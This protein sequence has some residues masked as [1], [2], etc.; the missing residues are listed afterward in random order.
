MKCRITDC[1]NQYWQGEFK[2]D[3]CFPCY[4]ELAS[5]VEDLKGHSQAIRDIKI[6]AINSLRAADIYEINHNKDYNK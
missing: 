1:K 5:M 4:T 6:V 2:G 3:L